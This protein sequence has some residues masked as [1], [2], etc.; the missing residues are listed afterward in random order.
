MYSERW[1][2]Q[3]SF[4][5]C[6]SP[7]VEGEIVNVGSSTVARE[8]TSRMTHRAHYDRVVRLLISKFLVFVTCTSGICN[9]CFFASFQMDYISLLSKTDRELTRRET[10]I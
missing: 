1:D 7:V 9:V 4:M 6:A 10:I 3:N 5:A 8:P 2:S